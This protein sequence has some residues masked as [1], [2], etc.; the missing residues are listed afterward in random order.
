[1]ERRRVVGHFPLTTDYDLS[2][3][4]HTFIAVV[5]IRA[6]DDVIVVVNWIEEAR[7][8]WSTPTAR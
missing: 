8:T 1:V 7:R 3:D 6:A 4:G 2:P 5:P